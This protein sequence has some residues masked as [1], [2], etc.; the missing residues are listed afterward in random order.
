MYEKN[1]YHNM[2]EE[3]K[4]KRREHKKIKN[5]NM[6]EEENMQEIDIT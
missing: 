3:Q 5:C 6:T 1:K 2:T 4:H